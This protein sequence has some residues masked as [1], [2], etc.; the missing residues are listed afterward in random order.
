MAN[1]AL[2][3]G[4][5]AVTLDYKQVASLPLVSEKAKAAVDELMDKGE[6]SLSPVVAE[7]EEKFRKYIGAE[8]SLALCNG[9]SCLQ[10]AIFGVGV[11]P[12]DEVIV[13]S[14]TFWASAAPIV[15]ANAVPVFCEV[16]SD[17]HCIDPVDLEKKITPKT[18]AIMV[19]HCWGTPADMDPIMAIAKK[20]N[21]K[22][23]EDCSHA[24]GAIYKGKKVGTIGDIG[25]FSLQ[26]SK[27]MVAG[28]GGIMVSNNRNYIE[29]A[30]AL[31][32][33]ER[34]GKLPEDSIYRQYSL[35]GMGH[36]FR[37]HPLGIAIANCDL[38]E[39]D[40]RSEIRNA[41]AK[42]LEDAVA[43]MG[44][45]AP[46]QVPADSERQYAYHYVR[47]IPEKLGNVS[48]QTVMKALAAEGVACGSC[49]Y[50][51]LHQAKLFTDGDVHGKGCP[52]KCPYAEPNR[53]SAGVE[54]PITEHLAATAFMMA[55]R[56]EK[57]CQELLDQYIAAY[58][59]LA[60]N[61]DELKAYE[62]ENAEEL[63]KIAQ[64]ES[65]RSVNMFR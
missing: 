38:D 16:D 50:G 4:S 64:P 58:R 48:L 44:Y 30:T 6:I 14:F 23:V 65:G 1:L 52:V 43:E 17:T 39:L 20:Y 21:L 18:K 13:P 37:A 54:L 15:A 47:Y 36:K 28:E 5:K 61:I 60:D 26:G 51:R 42:Y 24:H 25:C 34:L 45:I 9:T 2:L 33:Y 40:A 11:E 27:L 62:A 49:G 63:K 53:T 8:Y 35:T 19:V 3:G 29:R 56:L 22:V 41:N 31:G 59:K 12:G 57:P 10:S 46:Q 55:P 7:F 32:S